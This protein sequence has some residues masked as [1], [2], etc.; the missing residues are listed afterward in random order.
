MDDDLPVVIYEDV[1]ADGEIIIKEDV[2]ES[3]CK[4]ETP[5]RKRVEITWKTE[6]YSRMF[7]AFSEQELLTQT[8]DGSLKGMLTKTLDKEKTEA[9]IQSIIDD[10]FVQRLEI[11]YHFKTVL[12]RLRLGKLKYFQFKSDFKADSGE[13]TKHDNETLISNAEHKKDNF[14]VLPSANRRRAHT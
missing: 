8:L 11:V 4:R 5:Q 13:G 10:Y 14:F 6:T 7:S 9:I 3:D 12:S 1:T 2:V